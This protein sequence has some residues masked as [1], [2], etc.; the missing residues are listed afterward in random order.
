MLGTEAL[1]TM[2][3]TYLA[4]GFPQRHSTLL[5]L[6]P[7]VEISHHR[8][9]DC[10]IAS[11]QALDVSAGLLY[12]GEGLKSLQAMTERWQVHP[13]MRQR[14]LV[15]IGCEGWNAEEAAMRIQLELD[16]YIPSTTRADLIYRSVSTLSR[17]YVMLAGAAPNTADLLPSLNVKI[18]EL[19]R[20]HARLPE[21][22]VERMAHEAG[23]SLSRFQRTVKRLTGS[24]PV[25]YIN[26][27]KLERAQQLLVTRQGNVSDVAYQ[28][29]FTSVSYFCK[30]FKKHYDITPGQL[31]GE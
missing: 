26:R 5:G 28:T 20:R 3:A 16:D 27:L 23:M 17:R 6:M 7:Y 30:M 18:E 8:M 22:S 10:A 19:L 31:I 1:L 15:L 21:M 13:Q 12:A 24:S 29:G 2:A 4:Y 14:P 25:E 9:P 11:S